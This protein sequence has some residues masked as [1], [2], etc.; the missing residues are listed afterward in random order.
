M[1][2]TEALLQSLMQQIRDEFND[3]IGVVE[4]RSIAAYNMAANACEKLDICEDEFEKEED[5][6]EEAEDCRDE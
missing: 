3:K 2:I 1:E 6:L 4:E 5:D